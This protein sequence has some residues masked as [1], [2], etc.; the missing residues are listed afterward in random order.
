[1][2]ELSGNS[3]SP[4]CSLPGSFPGG[5]GNCRCR[6]HHIDDPRSQVKGISQLVH[7]PNTGARTGPRW[8][9]LN[10]SHKAEADERHIKRELYSWK[11]ASEKCQKQP[12]QSRMTNR[13]SSSRIYAVSAFEGSIS[14]VPTILWSRSTTSRPDSSAT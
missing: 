7:Q 10:A 8:P 14:D 1:M 13:P 4:V 6:S 3:A 9:R 2:D 5:C 12:G 11:F